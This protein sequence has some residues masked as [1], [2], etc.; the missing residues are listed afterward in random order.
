MFRLF[1]T[2]RAIGCIL[3]SMLLYLTVAYVLI[4]FSMI[5]NLS[6]LPY[7]FSI[8]SMML[9][10]S[11]LSYFQS[12]ILPSQ[13][14]LLII[15]F[16]FGLNTTFILLKNTPQP[17][18]KTNNKFTLGAGF[19]S[20]LVSGCTCGTSLFAVLGLSGSIALLPFGGNLV[21]SVALIVLLITFFFN[22]RS[23][24]QSCRLKPLTTSDNYHKKKFHAH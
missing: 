21:L 12:F 8:K 19:L 1:V 20:I 22:L 15:S 5:V 13:L 14:L 24:T 9:F 6:S 10:A 18:G 11:F 3:L 7:S 16:F 23:A 17:E 4:D 2:P